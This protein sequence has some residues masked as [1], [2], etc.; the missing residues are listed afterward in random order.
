MKTKISVSE[1]CPKTKDGT[2]IWIVQSGFFDRCKACGQRRRV[3][4]EY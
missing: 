3:Y 1:K 2:H 4:F